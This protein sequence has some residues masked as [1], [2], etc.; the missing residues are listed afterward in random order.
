MLSN[1]EFGKA[2]INLE[3]NLVREVKGTKKSFYMN[4]I[5]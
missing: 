3:L 5:R 1:G 2:M 4:I